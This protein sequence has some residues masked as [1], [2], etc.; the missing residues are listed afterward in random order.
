MHRSAARGGRTL[1]VNGLH[2]LA[3]GDDDDNDD[4]EEDDN[5]EGGEEEDDISGVRSPHDAGVRRRQQSHGVGFEGHEDELGS[6]L[7]EDE[8]D[9]EDGGDDEDDDIEDEDG[10]DECDD[11]DEEG[12][13]GDENEDDDE[14]ESMGK[15]GEEGD[16]NKGQMNRLG[17]NNRAAGV[18]KRSQR[19]LQGRNQLIPG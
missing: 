13:E 19:K 4:N 5:E 18:G 12:N 6:E 15:P 7:D 2:H 9:E 17:R 16:E 10:E 1:A 11:N 3:D 8:D 14:Q